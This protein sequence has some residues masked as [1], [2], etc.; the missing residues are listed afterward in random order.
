MFPESIQN[1]LEKDSFLHAP[2]N[3]DANN[4]I[5]RGNH[6]RINLWKINLPLFELEKCPEDYV[7]G[8]VLSRFE[9]SGRLARFW[10]TQ[11]SAGSETA[12]EVFRIYTDNNTEPF[13]QIPLSSL[14]DGTAGEIFTE[15]FGAEKNNY[16]AW[17][18]PVTFS[19]K[20]IITLD[21][22]GPIDNYF[23][24]TDVVMDKAQKK[25][26]S[27]ANLNL[28]RKK[29]KQL[30]QNLQTEEKLEEFFRYTSG[31]NPNINIFHIKGP[32]TINTLSLSFEKNL[33]PPD[34]V[35]IKIYW[36]HSSVPAVDASLIDFFMAHGDITETSKSVI[37][38]EVLK[39]KIKISFFLPMPF[40]SQA[41]LEITNSTS[42]ITPFTLSAEGMRKIPDKKFGYLHTEIHETRS[43][44]SS[45]T[46]P[47]L[48]AKGPGRLAGICASL[49]GPVSSENGSLPPFF[50][51]EGDEIIQIDGREKMQGT[52]TEDYFNSSYYYSSG[53]ASTPFAMN[54][55]KFQNK[56]YAGVNQCR[57][58]IL[59]DAIDFKKSLD[60]DLEIGAGNPAALQLYKTI[61][62][63]YKGF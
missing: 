7:R 56:E 38:H 45:S 52:G 4:F 3:L 26:S 58:H 57:W 47:L 22:L 5:C 41:R 12:D 39:D 29:A 32:A 46:H 6:S 13:I 54:W 9:G 30:L 20:L 51:L 42:K 62:Y 59:T 55:G 34:D 11:L 33:P 16:I 40:A 31:Q 49:T 2:G 14:Y 35:K 25:R 50:F 17:Y 23:H 28:F 15:P 53:T 60:F 8:A 36:N 48:H 1:F 43:P 18:Y 37:R 27:P 44:A 19:S 61:A 24:Q 10:L 21:H 63:F